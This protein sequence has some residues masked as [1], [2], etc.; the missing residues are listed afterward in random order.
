MIKYKLIKTSEGYIII[1][2]ED[3][4]EKDWVH[5]PEV[6]KEF[7]IVNRFKEGDERYSKGQ[8]IAEGVYKHVPTTNTWYKK[9]RKIVASTYLNGLP[10]IDF[11]GFEQRVNF[12]NVELLAKEYVRS[13]YYNSDNQSYFNPHTCEKDFIAGLNKC[14]EINKDKLYTVEQ[15]KEF[16]IEVS[17]FDTH[18]NPIT[19]IDEHFNNFIKYLQPNTEWN[20]EIEHYACTEDYGVCIEGCIGNC[21]PKII[22]NKIKIT[23]IL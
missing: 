14:L 12:N 16:A 23:K 3:V 2:D 7:T 5:H 20:I 18:A 19:S 22:D 21:K 11:N 15:M 10:N 8:H 4:Q 17:S 1:S 9:E 13:S 6:S